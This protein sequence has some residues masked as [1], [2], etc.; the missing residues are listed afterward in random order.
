ML[1]LSVVYTSEGMKLTC[2]VKYLE[3]GPCLNVPRSLL[4]PGSSYRLHCMPSHLIASSPARCRVVGPTGNLDKG[5]SFTIWLSLCFATPQLQDGSGILRQRATFA[6]H[7]PWPVLKWF[8]FV[9]RCRGKLKPG[10]TAQWDHRPRIGWS[11]LYP[12]I[13][14][15]IHQE[16][17][18]LLEEH[19]T[20]LD[21]VMADGLEDDSSPSPRVR[22]GIM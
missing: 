9:H 12:A 14:H 13:H 2:S 11:H 8:N 4:H 7:F 18:P 5:Q 15:T 1:T 3:L 20:I 17:T 22:A 6:A 19:P 10:G 16:L 21:A